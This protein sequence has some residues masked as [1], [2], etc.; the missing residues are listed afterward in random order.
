MEE[1]DVES[2]LGDDQALELA[3][4]ESSFDDMVL[5]ESG[6]DTADDEDDRD[7]RRLQYGRRQ[8]LRGRRGRGRRGRRGRGG[9][10]QRDSGI[11]GSDP[12]PHGGGGKRPGPACQYTVRGCDDDGGPGGGGMQ[13]DGGLGGSCANPWGCPVGTGHGGQMPKHYCSGGIWCTIFCGPCLVYKWDTAWDP[14]KNYCPS[15]T[16]CYDPN[17]SRKCIVW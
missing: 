12:N 4:T 3:L 13:R 2:E 1:L 11:P 17:H 5:S 6:D 14:Q 7:G 15:G 16:F 9:G 10:M 8:G